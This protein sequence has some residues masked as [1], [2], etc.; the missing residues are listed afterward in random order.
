M[1][2]LLNCPHCGGKAELDEGFPRVYCLSCPAEVYTGSCI[3]AAIAAWNRRAAP[4]L[5]DPDFGSKIKEERKKMGLTQKQL[6]ECLGMPVITI[7][8]YERGIRK[9]KY[10]Q[11]QK[12][13]AWLMAP[14]ET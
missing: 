5:P 7:Q 6:A 1:T 13:A 9:P 11:L 4:W 2:E 3:D 14:K 10:E 8:Q 12:I